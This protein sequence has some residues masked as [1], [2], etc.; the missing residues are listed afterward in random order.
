MRTSAQIELQFPVLGQSL[1]ADHGYALYGSLARLLTHLHSDEEVAAIGPIEGQYAGGN[2][3]ALE[4]NRSRL[5]LR[6]PVGQIGAV[7]PLAGKELN[8]AGHKLRLGVPTVHALMPAS[9][10][11]ARIVTIKGFTEANDLIDAA[12]RQLDSMHVAAQASIPLIETGEREGQPRRRIITIKGKRVV[13][14]CLLVTG[15]TGDESLTLQEQ[16]IGGRRKMGCGFFVP[17]RT[18][19]DR[20]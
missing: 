15:L 14:Y 19:D 16:G 5:R 4:R 11:I 20:P 18:E 17:A 9:S 12:R 8:V 2:R 10:L 3:L 1:P 13:G 7:L 6:M